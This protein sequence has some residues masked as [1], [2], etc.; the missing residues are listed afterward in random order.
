MPKRHLVQHS[1]LLVLLSI[2][3]PAAIAQSSRP[4]VSPQ[5]EAFKDCLQTLLYDRN[6]APKQRT[7]IP[8]F[9]AAKVCQQQ[10]ENSSATARQLRDCMADLMFDYNFAPKKRTDVSRVT[11]AKVCSGVE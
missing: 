6:F 8:E 2:L 5:N 10:P 11:A 3:P 4:P 1:L 9:V 7:E